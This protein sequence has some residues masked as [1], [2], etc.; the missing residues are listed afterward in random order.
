MELTI[1]LSLYYGCTQ[2]QSGKLLVNR[3]AS[4]YGARR[5]EVK[6]TEAS[7]W[8]GPSCS[9]VFLWKYV[10]NMRERSRHLLAPTPDSIKLIYAIM[11]L[12]H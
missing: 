10:E 12:S 4:A 11:A 9:A 7:T 6:G 3:N 1:Y 5:R 2:V 8:Q